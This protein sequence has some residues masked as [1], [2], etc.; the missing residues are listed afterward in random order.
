M[1]RP[2]PR[3]F[4]LAFSMQH[5]RRIDSRGGLQPLSDVLELF[6]HLS[7]KPATTRQRQ[8]VKHQHRTD[9]RPLDKAPRFA[10]RG[11]DSQ[12]A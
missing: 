2:T 7:G 5:P 6:P 10:R 4:A 12:G 1:T 8:P 9:F 11:S 3:L